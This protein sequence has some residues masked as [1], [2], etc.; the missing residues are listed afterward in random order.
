M[1]NQEFEVSSEVVMGGPGAGDMSIMSQD[2]EK[3]LC[4]T[5]GKY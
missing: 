3:T 1:A 2:V 5:T 4:I